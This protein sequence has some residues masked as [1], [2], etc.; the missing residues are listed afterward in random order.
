MARKKGLPS[1]K[2]I[3]LMNFDRLI[4]E[5]SPLILSANNGMEPLKNNNKIYIN[6][7]LMSQMTGTDKIKHYQIIDILV[8]LI[9]LYYTQIHDAD[10]HRKGGE[11]QMR[12]RVPQCVMYYIR[13]NVHRGYTN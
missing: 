5:K 8:M 6:F 13:A 1:I 7:T 4:L 10:T 2:L 9:L 12:L 3:T 11:Q